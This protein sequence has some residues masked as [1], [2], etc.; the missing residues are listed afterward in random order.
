[1][2]LYVSK[3]LLPVNAKLESVVTRD[4]LHRDIAPIEHSAKETARLV[5]ALS[6]DVGE[7]QSMS[8]I[9]RKRVDWSKDKLDPAYKRLTFFGFSDSD[10]VGTRVDSGG[11]RTNSGGTRIDSGSTRIDS[12]GTGIDSR[13]TRI[14]FG[15]QES[16]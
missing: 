1:M 5:N 16:M 15:A 2:R 3:Q 13:D 9:S 14:A 10:S 6:A 12:D 4:E 7:L 8:G 11:P